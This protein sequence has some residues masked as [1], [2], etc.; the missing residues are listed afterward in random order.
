M[1]I[2]AQII[3]VIIIFISAVLIFAADFIPRHYGPP[4]CITVIKVF[5]G[6]RTTASCVPV[7]SQP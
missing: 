2:R 1:S 6:G 7:R 4:S 3:C 5:P